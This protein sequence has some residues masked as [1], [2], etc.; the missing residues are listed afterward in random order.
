MANALAPQPVAILTDSYATIYTVP[1]GKVATVKWFSLANTGDDDVAVDVCLVPNGESA[2]AAY[3][4]VPTF[5][6]V[7]HD[8]LALFKDDGWPADSTLQA[9]AAIASVVTLKL[10]LIE[11]DE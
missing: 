2:G 9:K 7:A 5:T 6:L 3:M 8:V 4:I 1:A 11:S 10:N